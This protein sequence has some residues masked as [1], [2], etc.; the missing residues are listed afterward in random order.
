MA[1]ELLI[2]VMQTPV[3]KAKEQQLLMAAAEVVRI[4]TDAEAA[5]DRVEYGAAAEAAVQREV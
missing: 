5:E 3:T 4:A 1:G 2:Q